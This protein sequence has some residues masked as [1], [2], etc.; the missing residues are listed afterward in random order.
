MSR[1]VPSVELDEKRQCTR[2]NRTLPI[3]EF[4]RDKSTPDEYSRWCSECNY[5][6]QRRFIERRAARGEQFYEGIDEDNV[7]NRCVH[8]NRTLPLSRFKRDIRRASGYTVWCR[9]CRVEYQ[10]LYGGKKV[11][12]GYLYGTGICLACGELNP[13][14]LENH[15][16]FGRKNTDDVVSL[17]S[18][19]HTLQRYYPLTIWP[20][21]RD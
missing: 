19:C 1:N 12:R 13:L 18:N 17:C 6:Y 21:L 10:F 7:T 11:Q 8:C 5:K 15:H 4:Y 20:Q 3:S 2:C 16:L 14:L 9:D